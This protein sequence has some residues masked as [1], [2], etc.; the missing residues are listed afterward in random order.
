MVGGLEDGWTR[1]KDCYV[2]LVTV[3]EMSHY[4]KLL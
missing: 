1:L 4:I 2:N 3:K